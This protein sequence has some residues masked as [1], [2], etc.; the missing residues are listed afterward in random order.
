VCR[1][2]KPSA[3]ARALLGQVR[4]GR[5]CC[6]WWAT[7]STRRLKAVNPD[8]QHHLGRHWGHHW[9]SVKRGRGRRGRAGVASLS[10][11]DRRATC[12]LSVGLGVSSVPAFQIFTLANLSLVTI[13]R[14]SLSA[15]RR[16]WS[17]A[18][19]LLLRRCPL[20]TLSRPPPTVVTESW[21]GVPRSEAIGTGARVA[22]SSSLW[23]VLLLLVGNRQ[24]S[25]SAGGQS[26][27]APPGAPL[28]APLGSVKRGRGRRSGAGVASLSFIKPEHSAHARVLS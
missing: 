8:L 3:P 1:V 18:P 28:G 24:Y 9:G 12:H 16:S 21:W 4:C 15:G 7:V 17:Y 14:Q 20:T 23:P 27:L 13:I 22:G 25:P 6:P 11:P 26:R 2:R 19:T 10:S 5:S